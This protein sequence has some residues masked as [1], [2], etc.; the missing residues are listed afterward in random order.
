MVNFRLLHFAK[1]IVW[2]K[3]DTMKEMN[4]V[5]YEFLDIVD[6]AT[7]A[8]MFQ[9]KVLP[10]YVFVTSSEMAEIMSDGVEKGTMRIMLLD[11]VFLKDNWYYFSVHQKI[12]NFFSSIK[13]IVADPETTM[14]IIVGSETRMHWL[15]DNHLRDLSNMLDIQ[16]KPE[17]DP[18][19]IDKRKEEPSLSNHL[20][21]LTRDKD[22]IV[23]FDS[24][25]I[26]KD[27]GGD[28]PPIIKISFGEN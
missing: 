13:A 21:F 8:D 10:E 6:K 16:F 2:R 17:I 4:V 14:L 27:V 1:S 19:I 22:G 28:P 5:L 20:V 3:T 23:Q 7:Y 9:D 18:L 25:K 11:S 15:I 12:S 26:E 24:R